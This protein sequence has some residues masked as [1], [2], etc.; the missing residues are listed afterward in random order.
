MGCCYYCLAPIQATAQSKHPGG[1][2]VMMMDGT[3]QF[4]INAV[5]PEIWHV[6]H[7]RETRQRIPLD[8]LTVPSGKPA[9]D[10]HFVDATYV[11]NPRP[12]APIPT[13][14]WQSAPQVAEWTGTAATRC[15]RSTSIFSSPQR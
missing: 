8:R 6:I 5:D 11:S 3:V 15:A 14:Q 13:K 1:V 12:A 4:V 2:N 7:S 9:Y 10:M